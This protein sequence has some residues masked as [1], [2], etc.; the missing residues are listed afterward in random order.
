MNNIKLTG[1]YY[2]KKSW[3]GMILMVEIT[4]TIEIE[5][6]DWYV[7]APHKKYK[8]ASEQEAFEL[9]KLLKL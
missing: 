8:K 9:T 4:Y 7:D 6:P 5:T 1:N 2:F 3:F